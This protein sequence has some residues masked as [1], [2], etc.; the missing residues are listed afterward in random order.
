MPGTPETVRAVTAE[1]R[2]RA[3]CHPNAASIIEWAVRIDKALDRLEEKARFDASPFTATQTAEAVRTVLLNGCQQMKN[4]LEW[5]CP[6]P[7]YVDKLFDWIAEALVA[8]ASSSPFYGKGAD[9]A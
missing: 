5:N 2:M 3:R 1:M 8:L 7:E 4:A 9:H 6:T